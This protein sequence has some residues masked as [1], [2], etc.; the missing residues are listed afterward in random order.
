MLVERGLSPAAVGLV[1][2]V[3]ALGFT[4]AVPVWGHLGDVSLGRARTLQ[5]ASIGAA[6][7]MIAFGLPVPGIFLGLMVVGYNVF[8]SA[9]GPLA[10]ALAV[11]L[12]AGRMH[13]YGRIRYL[14]SLA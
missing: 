1:A 12:L 14:S 6:L 4:L 10:D 13:D 5:L 11:G 2:S 9:L 3:S 7:S 8:Q